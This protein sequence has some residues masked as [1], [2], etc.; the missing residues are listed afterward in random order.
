VRPLIIITII[1]IIHTFLYCLGFVHIFALVLM[2]INVELF[3]D[4]QLI[5]KAVIFCGH[6]RI[7]K[8]GD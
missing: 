1:I 8:I 6:C 7:C 3:A 2:C 4:L 5:G